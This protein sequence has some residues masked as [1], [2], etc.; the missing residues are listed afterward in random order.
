MAKKQMSFM[1]PM[2]PSTPAHHQHV[3]LFRNTNWLRALFFS[4][5]TDC[6]RGMDTHIASTISQ[7]L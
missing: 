6:A 2:K 7:L 1:F 4:P 3:P 5:S